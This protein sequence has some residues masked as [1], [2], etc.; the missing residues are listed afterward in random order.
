MS[1]SG[2]QG[3]G[4]K[5][6]CGDTERQHDISGTDTS[7]GAGWQPELNGLQGQGTK[8]TGALADT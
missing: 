8:P 4:L 7:K 1:M 2:R 3:D 6:Y 5:E